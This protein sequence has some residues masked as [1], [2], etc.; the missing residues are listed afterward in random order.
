MVNV[1]FKFYSLIVYYHKTCWPLC[2]I[3]K[4]I[5]IIKIALAN[6]EVIY[7]YVL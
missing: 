6:C 4:N 1:L 3:I 2:F 7:N 5:M